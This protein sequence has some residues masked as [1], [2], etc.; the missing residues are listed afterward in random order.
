MGQNGGNGRLY[1]CVI[2][3]GKW[4]LDCSSRLIQR[5]LELDICNEISCQ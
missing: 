1:A 4:M 2:V 5:N 3:L